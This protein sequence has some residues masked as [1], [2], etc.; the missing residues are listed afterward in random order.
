ME[1]GGEPSSNFTMENNTRLTLKG[2][3]AKAHRLGRGGDGKGDA[4]GG[5]DLDAGGVLELV[6]PEMRAHGGDRPRS[7][8]KGFALHAAFV[9]T[10]A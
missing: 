6:P 2:N 4:A 9:C 1:A 3:T 8:G 10:H 5:N 7:A